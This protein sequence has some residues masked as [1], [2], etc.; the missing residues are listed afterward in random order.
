[1]RILVTGGAGFIGSHLAKAHLEK[2]D[3]VYVIDDLSTGSLENIKGFL[4]NNDYRA[5]FFFTHDSGMRLVDIIF[6]G[7]GEPMI[8]PGIV[9]VRVHPLLNHAPIPIF[10]ENQHMM[11]KLI[12][13][14][15]SGVVHL[16][17]HLTGVD[18]ILS[19]PVGKPEYLA[20]IHD[21]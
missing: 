18:K 6:K 2:G 1:M 16:G 8:P 7:I 19:C 5:R 12:R 9:V 13:V 21:F 11:I 17:A 3:E 15:N 14:L 20:T 10:C 4:E